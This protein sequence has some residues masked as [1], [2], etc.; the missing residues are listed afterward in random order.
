M[1]CDVMDY[2]RRKIWY[3]QIVSSSSSLLATIV[4][5]CRDLQRSRGA[6]DI[7]PSYFYKIDWTMW[8]CWKQLLYFVWQ[9][10]RRSATACLA[11]ASMRSTDSMILIRAILHRRQSRRRWQHIYNVRISEIHFCEAKEILRY[12][13]S[14]SLL[15][16]ESSVKVC[17]DTQR[18]F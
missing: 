5:M 3:E 13:F 11:L 18:W 8:K 16:S 17:E 12:V 4:F 10:V 7:F 2:R 6:T 9:E 15:D 1:L 14:R